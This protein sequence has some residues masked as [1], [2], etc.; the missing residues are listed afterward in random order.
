VDGDGRRARGRSLLKHRDFVLL[1]GGQTVSEVGSQI[2]V[3]ALPLV[4]VVALRASAFQVG[5]LS[6]AGTC[7]YLLVSLPAG[8]VVDR[9][10]KRR[11]MLACDVGLVGVIGSVPVAHAL[12]VLTLGQLYGVALV[13]GVLS[14]FFSVAYQSYLPA[15]LDPERLM[16]GNGKLAASRSVAELAGPGAG[17]GLVVL[18]GAAGAMA[19]DAVSFA[20]SAA[21]LAAIR[22]AEAAPVR[23]PGRPTLRAQIAPG[24]RHVLGDPILRNAVGF[25]GT[26]NFF[27]VMVETLGPLFLVRELHVRPALVGLLI[28]M[29][30]A[31]GVAGGVVAGALARRVGSARVSWVAM[32]VLAA[33]GLL[34]PLAGRGWWALLYGAGWVSWTFSS[35]VAGISLTSYRQSTCPPAMLGRVSAATRWINWGTLPLGGLAG[36]AL[37]HAVGVRATLWVA[38]VG[39]CCS[40]LWLFFSP[41]RRM[42]DIPLGRAQLAA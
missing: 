3:L 4:A 22:T 29:G 19:A 42:R 18:V 20:V 16:D 14:V 26:A 9:V 39:G 33:P 10:R 5:L 41:L 15:L 31:G 23:D 40:G 11:V 28:A 12:G 21:G 30:A 27:V 2:S 6:A 7:A 35:V 8:A 17:A 24:V 38:A 37:A 1:W 36:G 25:Y 34:I 13:A 32:T